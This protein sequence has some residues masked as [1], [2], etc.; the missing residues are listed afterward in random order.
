MLWAT[1]W[2]WSCTSAWKASCIST[3]ISPLLLDESSHG[4][5]PIIVDKVIGTLRHLRGRA[6]GI[7]LIEQNAE[8]ALDLAD[9]V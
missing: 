1:M 3:T 2:Q 5:A 4:L 6:I 8:I 9:R 7:L